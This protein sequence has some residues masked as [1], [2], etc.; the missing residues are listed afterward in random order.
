MQERSVADAPSAKLD[1][2]PVGDG[3]AEKQMLGLGSGRLGRSALP[4]DALDAGD[5]ASLLARARLQPSSAVNCLLQMQRRYGNR[6]VQRILARGAATGL[7]ADPADSGDAGPGGPLA[8]SLPGAPSACLLNAWLPFSR[9]GIIRTADGTVGEKFEVRAEWRSDPPSSRGETSYCAAECGEYHQFVKGHMLSS[10]NPDGSGLQD[11]SAKMFGGA[12]LKE[13]QFQE[14]GLD[15][16]PNARYGHRNETQT[17]DEKY[18]PDRATGPKYVGRDFPRIMIGTFAD[19]DVTFLGKMVDTRNNTD[20]Q[21]AT[22]R[23]QYRGVI[24]P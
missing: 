4:S 24:R 17:M 18:D 5:G 7:D 19:I 21:S 11:D 23:V 9:S 2:G 13:D 22:W 14:D 12:K 20:N 1:P 15:D 3:Q 6:Y 10:P 16:N 8:G